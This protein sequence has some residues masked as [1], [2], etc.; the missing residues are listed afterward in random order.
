MQTLI[1]GL[2]K[3]SRV[4]THGRPF[5]ELDLEQVCR[6]VL[7]D[8]DHEVEQA[9]AQIHIGGL[10]TISADALQ[11]RQ[12]FQNLISNALKFRR[13][14]VVPEVWIECATTDAQVQLSVRDNGIGFEPQYER[15]IFRVFERLHGRN[16]YAGTGIGLALC[17][18]IV[19]RH[20][21][22]IVAEGIPDGGAT[23]TVTLHP[24]QAE[25]V[26]VPSRTRDDAAGWE[27]QEAR[28]GV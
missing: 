7:Q 21:G 18:K 5:V 25:A 27:R 19:E 6:E 24:D 20:G 26:I 15:R 14:G 16:E 22:R 17:R 28:V 11:M 8:L 23:F 1:E 9:G 4:A 13:P 2:L 10:P 3:F 12:L